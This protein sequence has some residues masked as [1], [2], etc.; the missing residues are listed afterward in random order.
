[1]TGLQASSFTLERVSARSAGPAPWRLGIFA[2]NEAP[3]ILDALESVSAAAG[4]APVDVVVLANGCRDGT[5][6][7]IRAQRDRIT[8]LWLAEIAKGDKANAWNQSQRH[9]STA[10]ERRRVSV[11]GL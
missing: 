7:R 8:N 1:M 5:V 10:V 11:P 4:G 6:D 3:R 9:R 2:H